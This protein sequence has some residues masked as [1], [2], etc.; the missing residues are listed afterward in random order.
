MT[1]KF[2]WIKKK[3]EVERSWLRR[4]Y[5]GFG[6]YE[7]L[8]LNSCTAHRLFFPREING[9]AKPLSF[10]KRL[11]LISSQQ[12]FFRNLLDVTFRKNAFYLYQA[13]IS[14]IHLTSLPLKPPLWWSLVVGSYILLQKRTIFHGRMIKLLEEKQF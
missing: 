4:Y 2:S 11:A 1:Y 7:H 14:T 12:S 8:S 13:W 10:S 5:S 3:R 9:F 6:L